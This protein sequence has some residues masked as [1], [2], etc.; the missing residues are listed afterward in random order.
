MDELAGTENRLATERMRYNELV[1]DYN[2]QRA[3]F[4]SNVTAKM[5]RFK[6]YPYWEV[7]AEAQAGAEGELRPLTPPIEETFVKRRVV[8]VPA[9][10]WLVAG[11]VR[12]GGAR[13]ARP[14]TAS[15]PGPSRLR[16]TSRTIRSC[17]PF[18]WRS[19]GPANMGGRIDDIAVVESDPSTIYVGFAT[20]GVWKTIEQRHD[21]DADLRRYPVSS[22]GDI[23]IAPSN[24]DIVYVGTGEPNNRQSSSFGDGVYKSIDGGKTFE[25][26]G[27][28][29]DAEHRPD[30]RPPEGS[31]HRLRRRAR[32][33]VRTEPRARP[34]QD[35]RRRQDLDEHEVHRRRHRLHRRRDRSVESRTSCYAASY[36]RRR[37]PW[38]FNGG[39]P[40]SGIWKTTDARQD[41][42]EADRQRPADQSD[43]RAHRARHRALEAV[44]DLRVDRGRPERRH[45]RRRQRRRHAA[46]ARAARRRRRWTG[47]RGATAAAR[48]DEERHLALGRWR[49][50]VEVP[51]EPGRSAGCTT[52]R[53]ASIRPTPRSRIRAARR[54]SRR[55]TAARRG[56]RCR[57][58]R[59]ATITRSGSIRTNGKHLMI[60]NDGG[61]DVSYDQAE[62]WEYVNTRA[63]RPVL[64]GQRRHAEAVLRLRRAAGQR[65][66][67]RP[68]R[69]AQQQRHPQLRL[70]PRRRR[71]RLLHRERSDRLG[72]S[73][74][75]V[76]G[77][78]HL[79]RRSSRRAERQH[80]ATNRAAGWFAARTAPAET[81]DPAAAAQPSARP[82]RYR[83]HRAGAR[84]GHDLPLLLEYTVHPVAA[85]PANDLSR[86]QSAVPFVRRGDDVDGIGR[87]DAEHR[88]QRSADHGRAGNGA[89]GVEARRRGVVQQHH[90]AQRVAGR[91]RDHLGR[92]RTTATSR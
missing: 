73:V 15:G 19:I 91:A 80:Q 32:A 43:H 14:G 86:R 68:E 8:R 66:L 55:S 42:D 21:L 18:V 20:G 61:L 56:S 22:I 72:D 59:T 10:T 12:V 89:D 67:V 78:R 30:R 47:G 75:G 49:E 39:G 29:R 54:S 45:R 35:D 88:P 63:G 44:D 58:S 69:D 48:S 51:V 28:E 5:F 6:E 36:Q 83:Q 1:R 77:R 23:A 52:A 71:R 4:P 70:V 79:A 25:Y 65:Q 33:P 2:T 74:F 85:Q 38:G 27:L 41:L 84:A 82:E 24:P 40:G 64:R 92:H 90:H 46:A 50:D 76:A 3:R 53:S 13:P 11:A 9:G 17:E 60:G 26:V 34:L 37:T 31:E 87:P 16:S 57:A 7:P 62:T 81:P